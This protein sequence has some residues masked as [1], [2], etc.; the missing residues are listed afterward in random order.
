MRL[1]S[2]AFLVLA[3]TFS[4]AHQGG[5]CKYHSGT[6]PQGQPAN[7][8]PHQYLESQ[9]DVKFHH[10]DLEVGIS[11]KSIRGSVRTVAEVTSTAGMDTFAFELHQNLTI[12]S[13]VYAGQRLIMRNTGAERRAILPSSIPAGQQV[14]LKI[15]Y[16]GTPPTSA[17][18]A[19][20]DGFSNAASGRWNNRA[21][22][23]LS[24]PY[25][26]YEWWPCKQ[27]LG[28][29]I[30]STWFFITTANT[31]KAGSNGVLERIV[32][33]S[34]NR[35]RYEW[36]S[37]H[38]I[39]YYLVSLAVAE[40]VDYSFKVKLP[41]VQDSVLV[42][43]YVYNNPQTLPTFKPEIDR[44][45]DMLILFSDLFGIYPYA[46]EKYGH[47]MAPFSGGME[48]QTM[49][50]M[51]FFD[52]GLIAHELGHQWFG[53]YVTC[54]SWK[55]LFINEGFASYSEYLAEEFLNSPQAA[56][57][58]MNNVHSNVL[59]QLGGS[60]WVPDTSD[61][62][63]L[64]SSRLS[65]DKG[66]AIIHTLRYELNNDSIFFLSLRN[67]LQQYGNNVALGI[68][69]K[70]VVESTSGLNLSDFFN[71]WYFGEGYP[72]YRVQYNYDNRHLVM[73]VTQTTSALVTPLFKS[74]VDF[75]LRRVGGRDTI[76][77][78]YVDQNIKTFEIPL[79]TSITTVIVDPNNWILNTTNGVS[80]D[81]SLKYTSPTTSIKEE[82]EQKLSLY[83]IPAS[84]QLFVINESSTN[85]ELF[86]EI[87][88]QNGKL[89]FNE[90]TENTMHKIN[91]SSLPNGLYL[92]KLSIQG[93]TY[94]TKKFLVEH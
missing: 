76:V 67:F 47:A 75:T 37:R 87:F 57:T 15:F 53:D 35:S 27:S 45:K 59:S 20:G 93:G 13:V 18:G 5:F 79:D 58:L 12:D 74:D 83:P 16:R 10:L 86:L 55:D 36:K 72:I 85:A 90:S 25:S 3:T 89:I 52:F 24:Q 11:N 48:H 50:T 94:V 42:Q 32:P 7:G 77:R 38:P 19:I 44:T 62:N 30:D 92:I 2:F 61:V 81:T 78:L 91:T 88:D 82:L 1:I 39:C 65:Y 71:Q 14:D 66:S 73:K 6:K 49:S 64:F 63:R 60:V 17:Q 84:N 9:Y 21:T 54:A 56:R 51:G 41:G 34:G 22:W 8:T 29:K 69:L 26:A 70:D 31:N 80:R 33:L 68:D 4:F 23:S 46:Y 40:Y 43:N 28:D